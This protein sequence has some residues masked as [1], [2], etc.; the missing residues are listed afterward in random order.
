MYKWAWTVIRSINL[1]S[2]IHLILLKMSKIKE[3]LPECIL[4]SLLLNFMAINS[5]NLEIQLEICA[6]PGRFINVARE[7]IQA[8]G[9]NHISAWTHHGRASQRGYL[10][11]GPSIIVRFWASGELLPGQAWICS[12]WASRGCLPGPCLD[13]QLFSIERMLHP[14]WSV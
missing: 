5:Y 4:T 6:W 12:L 1:I 2:T 3:R 13:M 9:W 11:G 8:K 10:P 14:G 7:I